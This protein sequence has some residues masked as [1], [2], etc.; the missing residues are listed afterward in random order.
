[1]INISNNLLNKLF[2]TTAATVTL[3]TLLNIIVN[4]IY[5]FSLQNAATLFLLFATLGF[6]KFF[7]KPE[8]LTRTANFTTSNV[9]IIFPAIVA[10]AIIVRVVLVCFVFPQSFTDIPGEGLG[11]CPTLYQMIINF[12]NGTW[13]TNKCWTLI[14]TYGLAARFFGGTFFVFCAITFV[15]QLIGAILGSLLC[16]KIFGTLASVI[17]FTAYLLLPSQIMYS[18]TIYAD[19]LFLTFV[20]ASLSAF[21]HSWN[22]SKMWKTIL[23]T[24]AAAIFTWLAL[25]SRANGVLLF[26]AF[27]LTL[28]CGAVL[29][30]ISW[31]KFCV[32]ACTILIV[33]AAGTKIAYEIND[34]TDGSK[35]FFCS[36]DSWWPRYFGSLTESNGQWASGTKEYI[37]DL[38]IKDHPEQ[39]D[40][41]MSKP[42]S[43]RCPIEFVPYIE[44]ETNKNW[45]NLTPFQLVKFL[46]KKDHTLFAGN[47]GWKADLGKSRFC[48]ALINI[49]TNLT[50]FL[51]LTAL[52]FAFYEILKGSWHID[53]FEL[54]VVP[55]FIVG[56]LCLL[57]IAEV[58]GRYTLVWYPLLM[59]FLSGFWD[60]KSKQLSESSK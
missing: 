6:F 21:S 31:K 8:H 60:F 13:E 43:N 26:I 23:S 47:A 2:L 58:A 35:T 4:K 57:L 1:M 37:R 36:S 20:I 42:L 30:K 3:L 50:L 52:L 9:K 34:Y 32:S 7:V 54:W 29:N 5:V 15:I 18:L 44:R 27:P 49:S 33:F 22:E 16:K 48:T 25:W 41:I 38:Y 10:L 24:A 51:I 12:Q 46:I 17:F 45:S 59:I 40:F 56:Y 19:T 14:F 11:D 53:N 28:F 39:K 55:I